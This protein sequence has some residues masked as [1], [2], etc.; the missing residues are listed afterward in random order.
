MRAPVRQSIDPI[1]AQLGGSRRV[2]RSRDVHT[3]FARIASRSPVGARGC[4]DPAALASHLGQGLSP[5][6]CRKDIP[7]AFPGEPR[8][9]SFEARHCRPDS[10]AA[11]AD[12]MPAVRCGRRRRSIEM[13]GRSPAIPEFVGT[14]VIG[15]T[16]IDDRP[17]RSKRCAGAASPSD[18]CCS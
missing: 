17:F 12:R 9:E 15:Q 5:C 6:W 14:E 2:F 11:E 16:Q 10:R 8:H 4:A 1:N 18:R 3:P 7:P 13:G